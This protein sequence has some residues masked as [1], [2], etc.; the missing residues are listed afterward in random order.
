MTASRDC[1]IPSVSRAESWGETACDEAAG[2]AHRRS[3]K[4]SWGVCTPSQG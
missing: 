2:S 3:Q 4:P 1:K